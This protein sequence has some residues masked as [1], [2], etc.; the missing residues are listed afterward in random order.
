MKPEAMQNESHVKDAVKA[1]CKAHKAYY[2][3]PV[4][5]GYG[6]MGVPDFLICRRGRFIAVETKFD[7]RPTTAHQDR[8]LQAIR[9]AGGEA[10]VV[11]QWDL[12]GLDRV[13]GAP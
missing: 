9:T 7:S 3:M 6:R 12:E 11:N 5:T 2:Y 8:E 10:Y 4:P 13:L 1:I